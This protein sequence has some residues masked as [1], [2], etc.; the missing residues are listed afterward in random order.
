MIFGLDI[1]DLLFIAATIFLLLISMVV[2]D[3]VKNKEK[4]M[5]NIRKAKK[6]M[7]DLEKITKNIEAD[8]RPINIEL[9]SYEKEQENNAIISYDELVLNKDKRVVSYDDE[10]ESGSDITVKKLDLSDKINS[11]VVPETKIEVT[12]MS[13]EKEEAFLKALKQ[14]QSDLAR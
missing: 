2:L 5:E 13:Y 7:L 1:D 14:L 4:S 11:S 3:K 8:Y 9:T 10:Y 6:D 12:L